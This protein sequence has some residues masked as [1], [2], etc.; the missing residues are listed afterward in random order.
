MDWRPI[1]PGLRAWALAALAVAAPMLVAPSCEERA[2]EEALR[3]LE[4]GD[5][6][7]I[8]SW[9][10]AVY[11]AKSEGAYLAMYGDLHGSRMP[12]REAPEVDLGRWGALLLLG[13]EYREAGHEM[14]V[15]GWEARGGTLR[16]ESVIITDQKTRLAAQVITFPYCLVLVDRVAVKRIKLDSG[17]D[18][19]VRVMD[20]DGF[21]E[22]GGGVSPPGRSGGI[23]LKPM[24]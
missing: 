20:L 7:G 1:F 6:S 21:P 17:V 8:R 11:W 24:E 23:R 10:P 12:A 5:M 19:P 13:G 2:G 22:Y 4:C 14:S 15:T 18:F 9:S 3:I 16:I